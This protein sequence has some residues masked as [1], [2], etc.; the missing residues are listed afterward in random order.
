M[1]GLALVA[2][3]VTG[4]MT[5]ITNGP[6]FAALQSLV[7]P[8]M[9]GRVLSLIG[10]VASA[11]SPLSLAV[12][13]PLADVFGIRVWYVI[14]GVASV[15]MAVAMSFIPAVVHIEERHTASPGR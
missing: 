12:A 13:G 9:Q 10:S 11:M 4:F 2:V 1:F 8:E 14:A 6:L 5:P 3:F 7:A 15:A